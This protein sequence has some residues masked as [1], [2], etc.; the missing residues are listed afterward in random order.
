MTKRTILL[1]GLLLALSACGSQV[2][3]VR[4]PEPAPIPTTSE[5]Q[6]AVPML[7]D[8]LTPAEMERR[9]AQFAP[10]VID[11]DDTA[12]EPWE[13][14]VLGRLVAAS[15]L[16]HELFTLQVSPNNPAWRA[17]LEKQQ[18]AGKAASL[19]Y[20]DVMVGPWDR[21][22]HD[23]PFLEVGPKPRGAGYY[24]ADM[25]TE[26]FER[27]IAAHP[28]DKAAFTDYFTVIR[29]E[30]D[31]LVAVPYS[32]VYSDKLQEAARLLRE[33]AEI[34]ED[35]TLTDYLEKRAAAFLSNDYFESDMAW[36]DIR[37]R[38]EPTIGPYEVYED[39]LFGYK[40]AFESFITVADSAAG[41]ELDR[42]KGAMRMLEE[43]L[44]IE[45]RY[46]NL[47]RG[48]ESPIRVVDV[49]YTAGDTRAGVQTIAFNLPNDERV[50][51]AKGSKKVMLRN[52]MRAKFNKILTPIAATVMDPGL[53]A[54]VEFQPWFVN[55]LMHELAHGLGPGTITLPSGEQTTVNKALR[56]HY[57]AL[58]EAKADV[59]GLH[60]LTVL[61]ED[62][63]SV[64]TDAFVRKAFLG[65]AADLFRSVRF[66][67][68][69]AHGRAALLQFNYFWD[70]GAIQHDPA[71]G[72]FS[73]DLARL[74]EANRELATEILTLQA[75]GS[76]EAAGALLARYGTT[77]PEMKAAL[78]RL[79]G[80]V[81]VD[82]RPQYAGA[83]RVRG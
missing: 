50:R 33:A 67:A 56:E 31:R 80:K 70:R 29:R 9:V 51:E 21:L 7:A 49:V 3:E 55:V 62:G 82:I 2:R 73:A 64:Y 36:M 23:R 68:S 41:A 54:Q 5:T 74:I 69:E 77:R 47:E 45:D 20:F 11:F 59:T 4:A 72:T 58:E 53:A 65:H 30:G 79:A 37:S 12:L 39:Q 42:L 27:W 10:A 34:S 1:P 13:K 28:E 46:K 61:A 6:G 66:G 16:M 25:T 40:A 75:Q 32:E 38:V 35:P 15:D 8:D 26:E 76:Y 57:S 44:P 63:D 19:I 24:P 78:D 48:F 14:E 22:D 60:N 52:V 83:E 71:T 81:P 17:E 43:N 18:G